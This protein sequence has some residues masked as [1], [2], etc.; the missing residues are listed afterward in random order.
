MPEEKRMH[1]LQVEEATAGLRNYLVEMSDVVKSMMVET[2]EILR[3]NDHTR[4]SQIFERDRIVDKLNHQLD[5]KVAELLAL[6]NPLGSDF[7][8]VFSVLKINVD[9]ER[10]GDQCKNILTDFTRLEEPAGSELL[11]MAHQVNGLL[12]KTLD[13]LLNKNTVAAREVLKE[14]AEIDGLELIVMNQSGCNIPSTMIARSLERIADHATNISES[15]IYAFEGV[16][17]RDEREKH[18]ISG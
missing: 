15:L 4:K 1:M 6:L 17:V 2:E 7:R 16:D 11:D 10:I 12:T 8:F 13:A 14:D 5:R 3:S 9:M 18:K